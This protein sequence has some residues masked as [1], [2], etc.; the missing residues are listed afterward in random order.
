MA[1]T[2]K[3][4]GQNY[5]TPDLV[6][7]VTRIEPWNLITFTGPGTGHGGVTWSRSSHFSGEPQASNLIQLRTKAGVVVGKSGVDATNLPLTSLWQS[8]QLIVTRT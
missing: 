1:N 5:I 3:L 4:V 2:I 8:T 6:A 7:K